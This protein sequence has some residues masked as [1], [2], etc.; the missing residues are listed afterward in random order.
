MIARRKFRTE[1]A[2]KRERIKFAFR[3]TLLFFALG[4][5]TAVLWYGVHLDQLRIQNIHVSAN[6]V[7]DRTQVA[8]VI[9]A[10][11]SSSYLGLIPKDS[12]LRMRHVGIE[13]AILN[14]FPRVERVS[15]KRTGL[16]TLGV[17]VVEREGEALWCGDVV[18]PIAEERTTERARD[19]N[20][21]W[22]SCYYI[23][24]ESFI[25]AK[26]PLYTGSVFARYYG[27][28]EFA[29]PIG[30]HFLNP[31]LFSVWHR[32]YQSFRF[33]DVVPQSLLFL[34]ERD[35]ELY[36][37]NGLKVLIPIAEETDLI[38]RRLISIL[39]S[40]TIDYTKR[41]DYIDLRFGNKAF[42][43]YFEPASITSKDSHE[44]SADVE[45]DTEP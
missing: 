40:G 43:K 14:E 24:A 15:L 37:S 18:P 4:A 45:E 34:D 10:R 30:Q 29:E 17:E 32:F 23:D 2:R 1:S 27:S 19:D 25:Y 41:V 5:G 42:V 31:E 11:F 35:M 36:L 22:G 26:A 28:L 21:L 6:G 44:S 39:E 33:E 12:I 9:E 8:S 16:R 20:T 7:L 3:L 38:K 13:Q